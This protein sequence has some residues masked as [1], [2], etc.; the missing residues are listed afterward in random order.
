MEIFP[1]TLIHIEENVKGSPNLKGKSAL[2][3]VDQAALLHRSLLHVGMPGLH[4]LTNAPATVNER[5][6]RLPDDTRFDVELL[7]TS[8]KPPRDSVFYGA[9]FKL[10]L[11]YQ[12][13]AALPADH[14]LLLLDADM[15]ALRKL[16]DDLIARCASVGAGVFDISDQVFQAYGSGRVIRDLEL[17]AGQPL[18]NPRW[19]GGEFLLVT[20][21]RLRQLV[22]C[23]SEHY[24][25]Y[26]EI[27]D[28]LLHHGD[29]AYVSAALN[30]LA[31][32]GWPLVEVGAHQA[33][34]RHWSGNTYRDLRWFRECSFLHLPGTKSMLE[35]EAHRRDYVPE[36]LW[37]RLEIAHLLGRPR[38][39]VRR[40]LTRHDVK[41]VMV[42]LRRLAPHA[43]A[44]R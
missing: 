41:Q 15:V 22:E 29:E 7:Q 3:Y 14:L 33:I 1:C 23:V 4:V 40:H 17:V 27:F 26:C 18:P 35:S 28:T 36:R 11:L 8:L 42:S 25:R 16:D 44:S 31:A 21:D 24:A 30:V 37:G 20:A 12:V 32:R 2:S 13:A 39:A 9:H 43:D 19:Y 10:D 6:E 34:G 38:W 5:L